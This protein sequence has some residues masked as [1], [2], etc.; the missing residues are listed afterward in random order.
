MAGKTELLQNIKQLI[1]GGYYNLD[2]ISFELDIPMETL[3]EIKKQIE[4]EKKKSVQYDDIYLSPKIEKMITNYKNLFYGTNNTINVVE[5]KK[6]KNPKVEEFISK[7]CDWEA[8]ENS[9]DRAVEIIKNLKKIEEESCSSNQIETIVKMLYNKD[10]FY[11]AASTQNKGLI[12]MMQI[13]KQ[14]YVTKLAQDVGKRKNAITDINELKKLKSILTPE[15]EKEFPINISP[16]KMQI[17][18]KISKLTREQALNRAEN[19]FSSEIKEIAA[20]LTSA[21]PDVTSIEEFIDNEIENRI[22]KSNKSAFALN[23]AQQKDQIYYQVTAVLKSQADKFEIWDEEKTI[24]TI[25]RVF[26]KDNATSLR[27]VVNNYIARKE[28]EKAY[29]TCERYEKKYVQYGDTGKT[30]RSLKQIIKCAEI[31]EIILRGLNTGA[32]YKELI[33]FQNVVEKGLQKYGIK[34]SSIPLGK[35]KDNTREITLAD[36]MP[37]YRDLY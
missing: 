10:L 37:D 36:I 9:I 27:I 24:D 16:V 5:E 26:G 29:S 12:R 7:I 23:K 11:V 17:D 35:N 2:T 3:E 18:A 30:A 8:M 31:G 28:F 20:K 25:K 4:E 14:R 6:D 32:S 1:K 15:M 19:N 13:Y 21:N 34:P 33:N 22:S